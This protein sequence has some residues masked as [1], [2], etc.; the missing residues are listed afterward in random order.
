M[1]GLTHSPVCSSQLSPVGHSAVQSCHPCPSSAATA[2][3]F[4]ASVMTS[5]TP[6]PGGTPWADGWL[7]LQPEHAVSAAAAARA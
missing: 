4:A 2:A 3:L 1:S 5:R 7:A 6:P